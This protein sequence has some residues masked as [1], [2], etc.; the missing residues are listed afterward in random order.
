MDVLKRIVG[1]SGDGCDPDDRHTYSAESVVEAV[2]KGASDYLHKPVSIDPLRE[3]IGWMVEEVKK[4][5]R[6]LQL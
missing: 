3:R 6:A 1:R 5:Q 4:R 2:Q